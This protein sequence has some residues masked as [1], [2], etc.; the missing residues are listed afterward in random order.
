MEVFVTRDLHSWLLLIPYFS[1]KFKI[2][3]KF[4][5]FDKLVFTIENIY[6]I[7]IYESSTYEIFFRKIILVRTIILLQF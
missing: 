4:L 6:Y 1:I 2:V 7:L 5:Y 3:W